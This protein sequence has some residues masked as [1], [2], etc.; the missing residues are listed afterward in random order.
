MSDE[1]Y[2]TLT[3]A[4]EWEK[5]VR[6]QLTEDEA[7]AALEWAE[8]E[9]FKHSLCV[10]ACKC[11]YTVPAR[12]LLDRVRWLL[13]HEYPASDDQGDYYCAECGQ[14]QFRYSKMRYRQYPVPHDPSCSVGLWTRAAK[15]VGL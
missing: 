12:A 3:E 2:V 8:D 9:M 5:R 1:K 10:I 4:L 15:R 7:V 11:I 6:A 14:S 13:A